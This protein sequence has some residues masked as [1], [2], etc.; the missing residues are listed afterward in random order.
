MSID[1]WFCGGTFQ[2][3]EYLDA[4]KKAVTDEYVFNSFKSL[5]GYQHILEHTSVEQ[6]KIYSDEII[7]LIKTCNLDANEIIPASK[8][9][10]FI[11]SPALANFDNFGLISP[12]TLRY[13][14]FTLR[15]RRILGGAE[16][17]NFL[18][19]GGGYGGMSLLANKILGAKNIYLNDLDE[20]LALQKKYLESHNVESIIENNIEML[21]HKQF[22]VCVSTFAFSELTRKQRDAIKEKIFPNCKIIYLVCNFINSER[23]DDQEIFEFAEKSHEVYL[24]KEPHENHSC[25]V[26]TLIKNI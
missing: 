19:I 15:L 7:Q 22:D 1:N 10:D 13:L 24:T 6:A 25:S 2:A 14:L 16:V 5:P 8:V 4:C 20:V 9:N 11:G 26:F 18:D 17:E 12:S 23:F 21:E 3:K